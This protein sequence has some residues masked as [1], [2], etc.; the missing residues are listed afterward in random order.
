MKTENITYKLTFISC[1]NHARRGLL[2][3]DST[4]RKIDA[5][6]EFDK[7]TDNVKRHFKTRFDAWIDGHAN[8]HWFHGWNQ[9]EFGGKYQNCY[10]FKYE[11]NRHQRRLYGFLHHPRKSNANYQICVLVCHAF[12][13]KSKTDE[14]Y[15]KTVEDIRSSFV[16]QAVIKD[17]FK[18]NINV[19]PLDRT[20]H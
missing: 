3:L 2:F 10:V 20:K 14:Y 17:F 16:V 12:K 15:L 11:D 18:E 5:K 7:F 9:T 13:N 8:K 6:N 1:E 19:Y 4:D